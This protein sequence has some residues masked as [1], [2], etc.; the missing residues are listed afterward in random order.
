[1]KCPKCGDERA[2]IG[3]VNVD[4]ANSACDNFSESWLMELRAKQG[5]KATDPDQT[6]PLWVKMNDW[7]KGDY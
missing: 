4:C 3:M 1:M 5:D 6:I 2:Y 7:F